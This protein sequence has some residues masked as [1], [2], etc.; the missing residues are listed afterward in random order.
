MDALS[1][2]GS[3]EASAMPMFF[4]SGAT[5][6]A[7]LVHS[8]HI[9]PRTPPFSS[10]TPPNPPPDLPLNPQAPAQAEAPPHRKTYR[11]P[12][13]NAQPGSKSGNS[14]PTGRGNWNCDWPPYDHK[15]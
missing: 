5:V 2:L 10:T 15:S 7:V 8:S 1:P 9:H 14:F 11:G 12:K 3:P 6:A 4:D 13:P